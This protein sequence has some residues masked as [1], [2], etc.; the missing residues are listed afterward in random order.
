MTKK[1]KYAAPKPGAEHYVNLNTAIKGKVTALMNAA[2]EAAFV[3][4]QEPD[5]GE[6][7][8]EYAYYS[9]YCLE[10]T[11]A[12][13]IAEHDR[14]ATCDAEQVRAD[15][16]ALAQARMKTETS[17]IADGIAAWTD[18]LTMA[19]R[20]GDEGEIRI[21]QECLMDLAGKLR[22]LSVLDK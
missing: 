5:V 4:A 22:L 20:G 19:V 13:V 6:W 17:M 21:A 11:I 12:T 9:R 15:A 10:T 1:P 2:D 7:L 16:L 3:G 14:A 18:E 8:I